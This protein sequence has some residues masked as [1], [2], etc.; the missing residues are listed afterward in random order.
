MDSVKHAGLSVVADA[1]EALDALAAAL[2]DYTVD[3][4]YRTRI[5]ELDAEWEATVDAVYQIEDPTR[6]G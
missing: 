4:D 6:R 3:D 2:G 5:A 1:R